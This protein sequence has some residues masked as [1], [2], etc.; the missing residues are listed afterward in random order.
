M[1]ATLSPVKPTAM[2]KIKPSRPKALWGG[3][4]WPTG[5]ADVPQPQP[6]DADPVRKRLIQGRP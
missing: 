1:K 2:A 3:K 4:K 6:T 5:M